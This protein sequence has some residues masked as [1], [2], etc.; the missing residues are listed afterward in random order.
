MPR[1]KSATKK[2]KEAQEKLEKAV[3]EIA[4]VKEVAEELEA[5][6]ESESS[7]D[8][9]ED[10][11]G[12]LITGKVEEGIDK[13]LS[14]IQ[15]NDKSLF[16]PN[17]RFF[18]DPEKAGQAAREVA[19]ATKE[20]KPLYL[21][22]YHRQN[23]LSGGYK[24]DEEEAEGP[25]YDTI[26][27]EKPFILE[28]QEK[29]DAIVDE[30]RKAFEEDVGEEEDDEEDFMKKKE[31]EAGEAE[32]EIVLPMA[33]AHPEEFLKEFLN[34]QAWIP[35]KNDKVVNL[36]R[37]DQDDDAEFDEAADQF[38]SAYNFRYEDANAGEIISYARDLATTRRAKTSARKRARERKQELKNQEKQ[39]AQEAFSKKK[40]QMV[41]MVMDRLAEIKEAVGDGVSDET[42]TEVFGSSLMSS[43]VD[44]ADW[45]AKMAQLFEGAEADA[46]K[47]TWSDDDMLGSDIEMDADAPKKAKKSKKLAKKEREALKEQ[48]AALVEANAT[49][50]LDQ[51]EEERGRSRFAN[52]DDDGIV[53]KYREVSPDS[54]GLTTRD[55]ILAD[56]QQLNDYI[57][58]KKFAPFRPREQRMK[59]KSKYTRSKH[60]RR[61][62]AEVFNDEKGPEAHDGKQDLWVPVEDEA[63]S[64]KRKHSKHG[65]RKSKKQKK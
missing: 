53:Y 34:N 32:P 24:D 18:D 49:K 1:K 10:E 41:N 42:I 57:A 63:D 4:P 62:R 61:W 35:K 26:D 51:V 25:K 38:E 50:V 30:I 37:I 28:E 46:E 55:I 64:K 40:T 36:D 2:A 12:D 20:D 59:D 52:D 54:F 31:P 9:D 13:V 65:D 3:T 58:I 17:V 45:D 39:A 23:Y 29:K 6:E 56:D 7:S 16:D 60:L 15:N 33:R 48:A 11:F 8:E 21:K 44:D 14:A 5:D 43:N 22:D 19:E 47:P 27:G